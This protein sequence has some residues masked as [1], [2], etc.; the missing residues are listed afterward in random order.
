VSNTS[1]NPVMEAITAYQKTAALVAAVRLDLFTIVGP[2]VATC[3]ELSRKTQAAPRGVRILCDS[4]C[5]MGL[6]EKQ[7]AGYSLTLASRL[8]LDNSSLAAIGSIIDFLAA[9]EIISSFMDDPVSYVRG[10]GSVGLANVAPNHP[11]WARFAK[12]MVPIA[13]P[14]AKRVASYVAGLPNRPYTV[15]D[16]AAGHGLYGIEVAKALPE[17]FVT[18]LDWTEVL[19]V[20]RANAEKAGVHRRYRTLVGNLFEVD[21][22]KDFDIILIPNI[23]H[24]FD[25]EGCIALL[26]KAKASLAAGGRALVIDLVPNPDRVSPPIQAMFAL[27]MLATTPSGDAYVVSEL[28]QMA[29][30]AGFQR[31]TAR[32]LQPTPHTLVALEC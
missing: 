29:K 3:E 28:E 14:T 16:V 21:W 24:H 11:I 31:A 5:V 32:A 27:F 2:G 10:G 15:L 18:A 13:S 17:A 9:P 6:L 8:F 19:M 1:I 25:E 22:G 26:R 30:A 4:L 12:S 23:L 7:E 20:A